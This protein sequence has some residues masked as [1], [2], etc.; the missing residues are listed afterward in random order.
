MFTTLYANRG[1]NILEGSTSPLLP[2]SINSFV[3][4]GIFFFGFVFLTI[5]EH[6]FFKCWN[7]RG[8]SRYLKERHISFAHP[9]LVQI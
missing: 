6:Q 7:G 5:L 3:T 9:W 1:V 4:Y 2:Y 8:T